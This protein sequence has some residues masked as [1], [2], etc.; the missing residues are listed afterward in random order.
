MVVVDA[1]VLVIMVSG[2]VRRNRALQTVR[3]WVGE[4]TPIH[5]TSLL[6]YE[7]ADAR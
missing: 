2:D 7:V 5:A 6:P 4:S 3:T 1:N